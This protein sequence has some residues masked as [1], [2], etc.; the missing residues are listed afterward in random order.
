MWNKMED[1]NT[2]LTTEEA[3]IYLNN[4][5][6]T[7]ENWRIKSMGPKYYK[8]AGKVYYFKKDLDA[9]IKGETND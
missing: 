7:L 4:A 2:K 6:G 8:P 1:E 9:W 5:A 3:A